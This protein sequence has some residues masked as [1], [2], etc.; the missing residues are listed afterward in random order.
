MQ[1]GGLP[2]LNASKEQSNVPFY[3][4]LFGGMTTRQH[5]LGIPYDSTEALTTFDEAKTFSPP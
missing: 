5:M 2:E 1:N 3:L 4:Q